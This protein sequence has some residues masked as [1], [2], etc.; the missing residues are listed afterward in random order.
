MGP[1]LLNLEVDGLL[2]RRDL[3]LAHFD[4]AIAEKGEAR[5]ICKRPGH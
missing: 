5:V 3:I 1:F 4:V 2:A